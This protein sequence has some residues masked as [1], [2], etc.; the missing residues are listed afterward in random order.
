MGVLSIGAA[1]VWGAWVTVGGWVFTA[2]VAAVAA[3]ALYGVAR[4]AWRDIRPR[5]ATRLPGWRRR[6]THV[7]ILPPA[8]CRWCDDPACTDS[9]LCDCTEPCPSG[10]CR[11]DVN[12]E[13]AR[14]N[15]GDHG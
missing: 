1:Q 8:S 12:A 9:T 15:G 3:V 4:T 5:P 11:Y 10:F 6:V 14:V 2:Q 13:W 7:V